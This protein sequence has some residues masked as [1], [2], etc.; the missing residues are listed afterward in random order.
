MHQET[1][2]IH[3]PA[4]SDDTE[5]LLR[6]CAGLG[7]SGHTGD[8][9]GCSGGGAAHPDL[10]VRGT[11][12][13]YACR[14]EATIDVGN[15][16]AVLRL[17]MGICATL[18]EPVTFV[19][20]YPESLGRRPNADLLQALAQLGVSVVSPNAGGTLPITLH[21]GLSRGV[22]GGKV[23]VSG[24]KSSQYISSLLFLAPLLPEGLDIE[25]VDGLA[26]A[27]FVDLT[28]EILREA[29]INHYR[30]AYATGITSSLA[31]QSYRARRVPYPRRLSVSRRAAGRHCRHA[32]RGDAGQP[33]ARRCWRRGDPERLHADG[34]ANYQDGHRIQAQCDGPLRGITFD[35]NTV[36]DSVPVIA[37][38]ACFAETSSCIC[39]VAHLRLKESDRINDLAMEL[40]KAGCHVI[41]SADAIEIHPAGPD[42]IA[43]GVTLERTR[44]PSPDRSMRDRGPGKQAAGHYYWCAS[45]SQKLS[46]LL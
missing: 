28:I 34:H 33:A 2:I 43:G 44:R 35:G 23:R 16:G 45:Y 40:N 20:P 31:M 37:A 14:Q 9:P 12:V 42:G 22:R 39:N 41:P 32:R 36:I 11:G 18:P 13:R 15:A 26:S 38:A 29:G 46:W 10:L 27:S 8:A 25:I 24:K 6:A 5:V 1:S 7:A 19:T 21:G 17:L 30:R 3:D 4:I